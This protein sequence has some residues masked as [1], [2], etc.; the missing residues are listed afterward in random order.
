ML[1]FLT[2][3]CKADFEFLGTFTLYPRLKTCSSSR[4]IP[5]KEGEM[6]NFFWQAGVVL[7]IV[8]LVMAGG[9]ITYLQYRATF[10]F[11]GVDDRVAALE[12]R[13]DTLEGI[14]VNVVTAT[15]TQGIVKEPSEVPFAHPR[16]VIGQS[17]FPFE[18]WVE[19]MVQEQSGTSTHL[20]AFSTADQPNIVLDGWLPDIRGGPEY[21]FNPDAGYTLRVWRH[22][23]ENIPQFQE[24]E[25]VFEKWFSVPSCQ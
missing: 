5:Y 11:G 15:C 24:G 13:V 19:I 4:T 3:A 7:V 20:V 9:W 18:H 16:V 21:I 8:A 12:E 1:S 17:G 10:Q 2:S 23:Y 6:K 25:L 22:S 14:I